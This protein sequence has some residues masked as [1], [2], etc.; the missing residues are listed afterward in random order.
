MAVGGRDPAVCG[1]SRGMLLSTCRVWKGRLGTG[2][3]QHDHAKVSVSIARDV[4]RART[5]S[6]SGARQRDRRSRPRLDEW[7]RIT[8]EL[9]A[10]PAGTACRAR[11]A[12]IQEGQVNTSDA[13]QRTMRERVQLSGASCL[14]RRSE[15]RSHRQRREAASEP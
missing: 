4:L 7:R 14:L 9:N 3:P 8:P 15:L 6:T 12:A 5:R 1:A 10:E 13:V 11:R 2:A